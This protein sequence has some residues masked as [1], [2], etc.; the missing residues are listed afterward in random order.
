[1]IPDATIAGTVVAKPEA[2]TE[3]QPILS[4]L[5]VRPGRNRDA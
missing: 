1:M 5:G 2:R 3:L 4:D